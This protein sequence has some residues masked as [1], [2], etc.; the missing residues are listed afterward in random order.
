M[1]EY[2]RE[3]IQSS[4]TQ[5]I[6]V[7]NVFFIDRQGELFHFDV[8]EGSLPTL[9]DIRQRGSV[10]K[11][12]KL[13]ELLAASDAFTFSLLQGQDGEDG[14]IQG[15]AK[16]FR[17][18][19]NLTSPG[20]VGLAFDKHKQALIAEAMCVDL[21]QP[22]HGVC[23]DALQWH[24]Q[25]ADLLPM[26]GRP[27]VLKPN[28]A[29][30]SYGVQM[31]DVLT[32]SV[33]AEYAKAVSEYDDLFLVQPYIEGREVTVGVLWSA[34]ADEFVELPVIEISTTRKL[35]DFAEKW[36]SGAL[37]FSFVSPLDDACLNAEKAS[38]RL[39]R[40]LGML[41]YARFDY[42]I[43]DAGRVF[44]LE[45]NTSPGLMDSSL[46]TKMLHANQLSV[47]DLILL[48][49]TAYQRRESREE[50]KRCAIATLRGAGHQQHM[51]D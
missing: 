22:M 31:C 25:R 18:P 44:F 17:L 47:V 33:I 12:D 4:E 20:V 11:L 40:S 15:M 32:E 5:E 43:D 13:T 19:C 50:K 28:M 36:S 51:A 7:R 2:M 3:C 29:G 24:K 41:A 26:L 35:F 38:R 10:F 49:C 39:F 16:F 45:V 30:G 27:C 23:L 9:D 46:F 6:T 14:T 37:Q 1:Y 34:E 8:G 42:R 48:S 21:L